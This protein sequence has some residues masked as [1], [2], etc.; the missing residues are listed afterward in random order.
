M[1]SG[2]SCATTSMGKQYECDCISIRDPRANE[3]G[4]DIA[5]E[6]VYLLS[7]MCAK[8]KIGQPDENA[9]A[10]EKMIFEA[11]TAASLVHM[12]KSTRDF[13]SREVSSLQINKDLLKFIAREIGLIFIIL[14]A[15]ENGAGYIIEGK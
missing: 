11:Y 14:V 6:Q 7:S 1:C 9:T 5:L 4:Y 3:T 13:S 15:S 12:Q 8:L 2:E 10:V